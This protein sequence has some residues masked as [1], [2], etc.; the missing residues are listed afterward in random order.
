MPV[1]YLGTLLACGLLQNHRFFWVKKAKPGIQRLR[2]K[3]RR[4]VTPEGGSKEPVALMGSGGLEGS[5]TQKL[6]LRKPNSWAILLVVFLFFH[7]IVEGFLVVPSDAILGDSFGVAGGWGR[8]SLLFLG[9]HNPEVRKKTTWMTPYGF[10]KIKPRSSA[11]NIRSRS[12][13][14]LE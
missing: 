10:L 4:Q 6:S 13:P 5:R 11:F 3:E 9:K 7:V 12:R 14:S 1:G 2:N 8:S